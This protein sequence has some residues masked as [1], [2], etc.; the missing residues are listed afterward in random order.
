MKAWATL[1]TYNLLLIK[2][3][4]F[5]TV[6]LCNTC[7]NVVQ[8]LE[9]DESRADFFHVMAV[10]EFKSYYK[11]HTTILFYEYII[12]PSAINPNSWQRTHKIIFIRTGI[13][14]IKT[15][16][17]VSDCCPVYC[18]GFVLYYTVT[19][20]GRVSTSLYIRYSDTIQ[21][22]AACTTYL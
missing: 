11:Y 10:I 20:S 22:S 18:F 19:D 2:D 4:K 21:L 16:W 1:V 9:S 3:K 17:Y 8:V 12:L 14:C 5:S 13:L 7:L 6:T 15:N